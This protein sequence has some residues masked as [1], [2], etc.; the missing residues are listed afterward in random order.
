MII[1]PLSLAL[2]TPKPKEVS[3][4]CIISVCSRV[5]PRILLIQVL[6]A[7]IT[8]HIA[9]NQFF[10][11]YI[12]AQNV[13]Q[14]SDLLLPFGQFERKLFATG[15]ISPKLFRVWHFFDNL[16]RVA[17]IDEELLSIVRVKHLLCVSRN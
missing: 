6:L 10:V 2:Y 16:E 4:N 17:L 8:F 15:R 7:F 12:S 13:L 9:F 11:A 1:R 14:K 3:H 5:Q